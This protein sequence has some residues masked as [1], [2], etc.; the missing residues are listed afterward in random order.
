MPSPTDAA[1]LVVAI[2]AVF[3]AGAIVFRAIVEHPEEYPR[4]EHIAFCWP[5]GLTALSIPLFLLSWAGIRV[6]GWAVVAAITVAY[7]VL[8]LCRKRRRR[9]LGAEGCNARQSKQPF[10]DFERM[11]TLIIVACL[12]TQFVA[13][14]L[15]PLSD[16]DSLSNWGFKG[17][18]LFYDTL[19]HARPYWH[20][21]QYQFTNQLYPLLVPVMYSWVCKILGRWDD[22]EMLIVNPINLIVFVLLLYAAIRRFASRATALTVTAIAASLPAALH[23]AECGQG[24]VP[25][26]LIAGASLF[27]LFDWMRTR[28]TSSIVL[29]AVLM[30]GAM[31]TKEEGKV[32]FIGQLLAVSGSTFFGRRSDVRL[33]RDIG[34]YAGIAFLIA[35]P[36]FIFSATIPYPHYQLPLTLFTPRWKELPT[37]LWTITQN[38]YHFFNQV[39][40][41]KWNLLWILLPVSL[42]ATKSWRRQPWIW[43]VFLAT[44]QATCVASIV[45]IT[46]PQ[47]MDYLTQEIALERYTLQ[48]LAPLWLVL[49]KCADEVNG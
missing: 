4:W 38:D 28:R 7:A 6:N 27:C 47:P 26:M 37:L 29:S 18:I 33:W 16:W 24:D 11:L 3:M 23:Y 25:L 9:E 32:L 35:L 49:A 17:K 12:S 2:L 46:C 14:L 30:G 34:I 40:L 10:S 13:C 15:A 1:R 42:L 43:L 45:L 22:C 8:H 36:Y 48:L 19:Q 44:F 39:G 21:G 5:L 20:D 31:F 41:P